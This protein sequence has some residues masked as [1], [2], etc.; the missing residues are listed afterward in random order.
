VTT[1]VPQ[2]RPDIPTRQARL[3]EGARELHRGILRRFVE[4]GEAPD[5][6][7]LRS[8]AAAAGVDADA[9]LRELADADLVHLG[10]GGTVKVAYPFSGVPTGVRVHL[11]GGP[12]LHAMCA[13]DALGIPPMTGRDAVIAATDPGSSEPVEVEASGGA[14]TWRPEHAVVL[15]ANNGA[16]QEATTADS[17]CP[18]ITFHTSERSATDHLAVR[19]HL[20][21]KVLTQEQAQR[22]GARLFGDLLVDRS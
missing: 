9:G 19:D 16:G 8:L 20:T 17:A 13:V 2:E 12:A 7:V 1:E 22:T 11:R 15:L 18:T 14:W 6:E 3:S 21:G 4:S 10:E 5:P